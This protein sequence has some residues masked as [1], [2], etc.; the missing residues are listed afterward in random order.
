MAGV[1]LVACQGFMVRGAF[2]CFLV[3]QAGYLLCG[4][5]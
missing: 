2:V 5:Q 3:C 4:V 1:G